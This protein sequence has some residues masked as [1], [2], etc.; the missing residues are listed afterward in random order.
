MSL[1]KLL[2]VTANS[3]SEICLHVGLRQ[4]A[5]DLLRDGLAPGPFLEQ[6]LD[7]DYYDDAVRFLAHAL[8]QREAVWWGCL[9]VGHAAGLNATSHVPPALEAAVRW[10]VDPSEQNRRA[11]KGAGE[12]VERTTPSG[13]L[14]VAAFCS[15]SGMHAP[16]AAAVPAPPFLTAKAVGEAILLAASQRDPTRADKPL[17]EFLALGIGIADG[18][19][20]WS[21]S[22]PPP[23]RVSAPSTDQVAA[24]SPESGKRFP[25]QD[26][27]RSFGDRSERGRRY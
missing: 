2:R 26:D 7:R 10:V 21:P 17:R 15:G 12:S 27:R 25:K 20:L 5:R 4:E 1:G 23:D 14:A 6:L 22:L 19:Y 13:C 3:A 8:P 9:C 16:N 24:K 11:A 18:K